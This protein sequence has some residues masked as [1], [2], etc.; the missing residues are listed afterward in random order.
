VFGVLVGG[1]AVC[2][3]MAGVVQYT[4]TRMYVSDCAWKE[5]ALVIACLAWSVVVSMID[6]HRH[7]YGTV[8]L[9]D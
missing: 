8:R 4:R 3:G 1:M 6:D 9:E 5:S 7:Q 2:V